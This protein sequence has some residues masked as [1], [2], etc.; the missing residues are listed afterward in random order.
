MNIEKFIYL[1]TKVEDGLPVIVKGGRSDIV[2]VYINGDT[3]F[4]SAYLDYEGWK[5]IGCPQYLKNISLTHW[6]NLSK[7]TTKEKALDLARD[8]NKDTYDDTNS[9]IWIIGDIEKYLKHKEKYL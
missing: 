4:R 1:F 8:T 9:T 6:L 2:L 7:L 5:I 3:E